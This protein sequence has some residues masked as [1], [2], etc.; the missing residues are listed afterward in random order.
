MSYGLQMEQR[1]GRT[2]SLILIAVMR[3]GPQSFTAAGGRLF[4]VAIVPD[5]ANYTV[6]TQL[7]MTDGTTA[8]TRIIYQEPGVSYGYSIIE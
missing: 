1:T 6:R 3:S 7:W 2:S 5:D 4:F 8:G